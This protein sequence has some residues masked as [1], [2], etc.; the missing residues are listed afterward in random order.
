MKQLQPNLTEV[1]TATLFQDSRR[2]QTGAVAEHRYPQHEMG[3]QGGLINTRMETLSV[4]GAS[5]FLLKS[6][7]GLERW[8]SSL[9]LLLLFHRTRVRFPAPTAGNSQASLTFVSA[10][11]TVTF[12]YTTPSPTYT[13]FFFLKKKHLENLMQRNAHGASK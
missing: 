13:Y 1:K 7:A 4:N 6:W 9:Q 5:L 12:T 8:L 10:S 2:I 11:V 3:A